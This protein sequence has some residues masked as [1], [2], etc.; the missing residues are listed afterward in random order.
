MENVS[1]IFRSLV[2]DQRSPLEPW[3]QSYVS[4]IKDVQ[5]IRQKLLAN[6]A[7]SIKDPQLY[8]GLGITDYNNLLF[9]LIYEASNGVS[10]KGRATLPKVVFNKLYNDTA[11]EA[12]LKDTFINPDKNA[13]YNAFRTWWTNFCKANGSM[14]FKML[15]NRAVAAI[16]PEIATVTVDEGKFNEV[17]AELNQTCDFSFPNG[18]WLAK[19]IILTQWLDDKIKAEL[20]EMDKLY[21]DPLIRLFYR[22]VFTWALFENGTTDLFEL[23]KQIIKYGPPGTG[24]TYTCQRN[25]FYHF[26]N[27][28]SKY[29]PS[30]K[31]NFENHVERIQFHPSFTY[32]DFI[33]GLRPVPDE[34]GKTALKLVPGIFKSFCKRASQWERDVYKAL[35]DHINNWENLKAK[36]VK[37]KVQ[38]DHWSFLQDAEDDDPL[39]KLIPPYYF[40]ID[41]INRAELSRVFG[42]L[43]FSLEYRGYA[44]KIKTQYSQLAVGDENEYWIENGQ[45]FFFIPHNL[46]LFGTMNTIDRSV[47]SF[48]FALRRRF[49]W[50]EVLPNYSVAK[51]FFKE[52]NCDKFEKVVDNLKALN[53]KISSDTRL[54]GKDYQIGHSYLMKLNDRIKTMSTQGYNQYVWQNNLFPLLEEYLRGTAEPGEI[55]NKLEEL[56]KAFVTA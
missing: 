7:L 45:N 8:A 19:N 46:F 30:F 12:I 36:H 43:M 25:A 38:G 23:H 51:L 33:E 35:P 29:C 39:D 15:V 5:A 3:K 9:R 34:A 1:L 20:D 31:G 14:D 48:D 50:K 49:R 4:L 2:I 10:G 55:K 26:E 21:N 17:V 56:K 6:P 11:F 24:K 16:H 18:S 28:T 13:S 42:E 32:E 52:N 37:E 44:G 47:E 27:W 41:E 40:I 54:L 53:D 22:N